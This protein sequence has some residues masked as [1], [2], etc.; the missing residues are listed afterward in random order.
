[1]RKKDELAGFEDFVKHRYFSHHE[2][3]MKLMQQAEFDSIAIVHDGDFEYSTKR[4]FEADFGGDACKLERWNAYLRE[5]IPKSV[6]AQICFRDL[7]DDIIMTFSKRIYRAK[8]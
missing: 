7:G 1:M 5:N 4:L 6:Q 8:K 2:E 3:L